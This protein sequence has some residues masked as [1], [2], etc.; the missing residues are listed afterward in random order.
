MMDTNIQIMAEVLSILGIAT[1]EVGRGWLSK[2]FITNMSPLT[3]RCS[4]KYWNKIIG[5]NKMEGALKRLDKLTQ[6]EAR[7]ATAEVLRVTHA[8]DEGI[9]E[10]R[11][12]VISVDDKAVEVING[13]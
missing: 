8:I 6:E 9:R 7:M 10:V 11:E 2:L 13:A 5:G 12:Q 4:E 3:E 1:K